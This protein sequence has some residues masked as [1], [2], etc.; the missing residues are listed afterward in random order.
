[1]DLGQRFLLQ[2]PVLEPGVAAPIE[3]IILSPR[4]VW[5]A[6][7]FII[8]AIEAGR[9]DKLKKIDFKVKLSSPTLWILP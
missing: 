5:A 1:L 7:D 2:P 9:K 3:P 8:M 4:D 6:A